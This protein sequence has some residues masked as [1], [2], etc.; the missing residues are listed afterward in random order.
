MKNLFIIF[1]LLLFSCDNTQLKD[2]WVSPEAS[3]YTLK[4]VFI[5]GLTDNVEA[6]EKF[7][8]NLQ[9]QLGI[10]GIE[11]SISFNKFE[12]DFLLKQKSDADIKAIEDN[13]IKEGYDA[14]LFTKVAGIKNK[15]QYSEDYS[16]VDKNHNRFKDDYLMYQDQFF[17]PDDYKEYQVYNAETSV[18]CLCP[19]KD[20]TLIWKGYIDIIDPENI[21]KTVADYAKLL[22]LVLEN[23]GIVPTLN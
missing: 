22:I 23:D 18:Y 19:T 14:V 16:K 7:E 20:R 21:N 13:L 3:N 5:V 11:T 1:T 15:I 9:K 10:R 2:H 12:T 17:N 4:K 8:K 6:R